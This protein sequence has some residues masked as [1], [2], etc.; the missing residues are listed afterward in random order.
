MP[1]SA[2]NHPPFAYHEKKETEKKI[3]DILG[4]KRG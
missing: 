2:L 3:F 4:E 1:D